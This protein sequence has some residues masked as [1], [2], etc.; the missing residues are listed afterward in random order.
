MKTVFSNQSLQNTS[1]VNHEW[2]CVE[3]AKDKGW[4]THSLLKHF[5]CVS[6]MANLVLSFNLTD[7]SLN[8][9]R[10]LEY[11]EEIHARHSEN[12]HTPHRQAPTDIWT[13]H[14]L[15]VRWQYMT[16]PP[17]CRFPLCYQNSSE[18]FCHHGVTVVGVWNLGNCQQ[19]YLYLWV[20]RRLLHSVEHK[21]S[22]T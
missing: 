18:L 12:T 14:L 17:T 15:A 7:M 20:L 21:M 2:E 5:I 6:S 16:L 1:F 8:C 13:N 3:L 22:H 11:L 10:R 9:G 4:F 19:V